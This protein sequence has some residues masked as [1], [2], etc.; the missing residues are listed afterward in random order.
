LR[1]YKERFNLHHTRASGVDEA[2]G[3]AKIHRL[4]QSAVKRHS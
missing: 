4:G 3:L 1:P 2:D